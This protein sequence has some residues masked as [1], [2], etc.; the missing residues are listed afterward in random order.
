M[1][2]K[3]T[4]HESPS[5]QLV[6]EAVAE[7]IVPDARGRKITLRKPAVIQQFRLVRL[8]GDA[9]ANATYMAMVFPLI[10]VTAI[11]GDPVLPPQKESEIEA[12][13]QRLDEDGIDAVV[14]GVGE[15]WGEQDA[16]GT[17]DLAKKSPPVRE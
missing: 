2:P 17:H 7:Q 16:Q 14:K 11:D 10:F 6:R 5:Q 13:I 4:V 8:L 3:V 12:L 9:A 1:P 15:Y